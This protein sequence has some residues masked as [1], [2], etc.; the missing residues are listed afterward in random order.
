MIRANQD[1]IAGYRV[2]HAEKDRSGYIAGRQVMMRDF[3]S[4]S[5]ASPE[6]FAMKATR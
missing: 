5:I 1:V 6:L 4:I 3:K 2:H